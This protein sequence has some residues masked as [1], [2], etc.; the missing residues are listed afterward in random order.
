MCLSSL[1]VLLQVNSES[2]PVFPFEGNA[3]RAVDVQAVSRRFSLQWVK[4]EA[5]DVQLCKLLRGIENVQAPE[6]PFMEILSDLSAGVGLEE[7]LEAL[8][9]EGLDHSLKL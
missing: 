7:L 5:R 2:V 1:V 3:P 4:V 8:V 9:P 6:R